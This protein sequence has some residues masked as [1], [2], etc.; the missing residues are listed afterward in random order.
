M[1]NVNYKVVRTLRCRNANIPGTLG[2]LA[3][4]IGQIG[5]EIGN[6]VTVH[7]GHHFTIRDIDVLVDSEG[8]LAELIAKV[9][10]LRD[11]SVLE[12]R[13]DV[14]ELH[15][16]G[17]IKMPN[18]IQINSLDTLQKI[19]TPGVAEV[20]QLIA[21]Q[22]HWKDTYTSIPN[23]IAIVTDGTAVL[24]L[25]NIGPVAGMPVM[26]AKAALLYQL[27]GIS[28]IP[29]LL[30]TTDADEI[31]ETVKN[32]APTFAGIHLEDIASPRC[33]TIEETLAGDLSIPVMHDDQRGTAV[34]TLA[35]LINAC[36]R[37]KLS[38]EEARIGII[39][40]GTA[41][42]A[43]ARFLR[44]YIGRPAL[45]TD[46]IEANVR[47]YVEH[48]GIPSSLDEIMK[49]ADIVIAVT[50]VNGLISPSMIKKGQIIFALSNPYPEIAPG[51]AVAAGAAMAADGK[52]VNNLLAYPGTWRGTLDAKA[53]KINFEMYRAA[54]LA[55]AG[56]T[57]EG[58]LVPNSLDPRMHLAVTHAV[59][60]AAIESGVAGR[61]LD[62]DYFEDTNIRNYV[63]W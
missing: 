17:I 7:L 22:P 18:S 33:F 46:K 35:A 15:K 59:A 38:L 56:T 4:T 26:E 53:K 21:S 42:F 32:I 31:I 62:D 27:S 23:F 36:Q 54:S 5:A 55:I 49:K 58:E 3:V 8:H 51:A 9:S 57:A 60:R 30:N 44:Q 11:V 29:I 19:Y 34:V 2:K 16:H 10:R 20:C 6:I 43:I 28:G 48:G 40:L 13:D 41:G 50:A 12:V 37:T 39:G 61:S 1:D 24:G 45:G 47:R 25:G 14:L 52:T 63:E